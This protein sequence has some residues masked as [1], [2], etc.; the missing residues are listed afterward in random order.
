[1]ITPSATPPNGARPRE[2]RMFRRGRGENA[3]ATVIGLGLGMLM[4]PFALELYT[5]SFLVI[6]L[7]TVGYLITSHLPE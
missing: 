4:Q 5:W 1:M 7:G 2:R 6:L 3:S